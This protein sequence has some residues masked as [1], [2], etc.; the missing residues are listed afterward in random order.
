VVLSKIYELDRNKS[1]YLIDGAKAT[2]RNFASV[3][4]TWV[5]PRSP[6]KRIVCV[7][8]LKSSVPI[9]GR[10]TGIEFSN[11]GDSPNITAHQVPSSMYK[12][13]SASTFSYF[14]Y[15]FTSKVRSVTIFGMLRLCGPR[16]FSNSGRRS[17]KN[18][19]C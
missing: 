10:V 8:H 19:V 13:K 9:S 12:G 18:R 1:P 7:I 4:E 2:V 5:I 11:V 17:R 3:Q 6:C 15:C 16:L 14:V